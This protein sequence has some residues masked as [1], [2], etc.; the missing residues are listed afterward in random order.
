M[1]HSQRQP[2]EWKIKTPRERLDQILSE[3]G[4][5]FSE[6]TVG[7]ETG[8]LAAISKKFGFEHVSYLANSLS[9]GDRKLPPFVQTT[10][11]PEW[12]IFYFNQGF[13]KV[14]PTIRICRHSLMGVNW[15]TLDRSDPRIA[16]LFAAFHKYEIGRQGYSIPTH[17]LGTDVSLLSVTG[18][19]SSDEWELKT[20]KAEAELSLIAARLHAKILH[21]ATGKEAPS[22]RP[23]GGREREV[24]NW[25]ARGKTISETAQIINLS[26]RSVEHYLQNAKT[27]LNAANTVH[28]VFLATKLKIL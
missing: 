12:M 10:F 1:E 7:I 26:P 24:L 11:P 13:Q 20:R 8:E 3:K 5:K 23:L 18:N 21:Q 4:L 22:V 14:D 27:K 6:M 2:L 28:A 9:V 17:G 15:E 19:D 25:A 16:S